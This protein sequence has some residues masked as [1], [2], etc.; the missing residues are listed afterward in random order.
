M[1]RVLYHIACAVLAGILFSIAF[2]PD[3]ACAQFYSGSYQ[4]FGKNRI[5]YKNFLWTYYRFNDFDV[6]FYLNGQELAEKTARYANEVIP[7]MEKKLETTLDSKL[8]FLVYNNLSDL[9]QSN[10]GLISDD[11]YNTGGITHIIGNKVFIYFDGDLRNF[12]RQIRSGIAEVLLNQLFLGQSIGSQI[13]NTTLYSLPDWYKTG[14]I[15]YVSE[16]WSTELDNRT[17]DGI[18]SGKFKKFNHLYGEDAIIAGHSF[19][20]FIAEQYGKNSIAGIINMT[21]VSHNLE[22]G[23]LYVIGVS[24]KNLVEEWLNFYQEIYQ[25][26]TIRELPPLSV[27]KRYKKDQV[28]MEPALSPDGRKLAFA[29]NDDGK[30]IIYVRDLLTGK[31]QRIFSGGYRLEDKIDYSYPLMKWNP[32]GEVL[33]FII[34]RK[35]EIY[36]YLYSLQDRRYQKVLLTNFEKVADYDYSH[37]GR[38]LVFSAVQKGQSDIYVYNISS[39]SHRQ[40]TN[41]LYDDLTPVF[42]NNSNSII[43]AS[44]RITDTLEWEPEDVPP[45]MPFSTDLFI[46]DYAGNSQVLKRLT[47]TP[48][49]QEI[50]PE[51]SGNGSF[52]F[53][54][55]ENGIFN[56]HNGILDSAI[57]YIDTAVHYRYFAN[58]YP[59]TDYSRSI[60][61]QDISASSGKIAQVIFEGDRY[62][63]FLEDVT[64]TDKTVRPAPVNTKYRQLYL[65][66][67]AKLEEQQDAGQEKEQAPLDYKKTF[68][69][70]Y[71][72]SKKQ[73]DQDTTGSDMVDIEDYQ[74]EKQGSLSLSEKDKQPTVKIGGYDEEEDRF[75]IPKKLN[76]RVEYSI[77][78]MTTQLDFTALNYF[79]QP[80][81]NG[82]SADFYNLGLNG[83]F[84]VSATD[85]LEDHRLVGGFRIP[86]NLR[87]IEYL[88]S[89]SNMKRRLNRE[90]VFYRQATENDF[91]GGYYYFIERFRSYQFYYILTY[92]FTPVLSVKGTGNVRYQKFSKLST[93]DIAL[94]APDVDEY[95]GGL[96]GELIYD[97]TKSLGLNLYQGTRG[98]FFT[99]Y[100]QIFGEK[101]KNMIVMGLDIRNYLKIHRVFIW[102]NRFAASRSFGQNKLLYYMGGVD[103]WLTP[104]FQLD[105]PVDSRQNYAYQTLAT[106]MRGFNQNSR[107]GNNFILLNSELRFPVFRYFYNRP[108]QSEFV[109]NFQIVAFGDL[110]TAWAGNDPYSKENSLYTSVI[111]DGSLYITVTEQKEPLIGGFGFGARSTLFG[112][113][114]RGDL[115][116][117]VEDRRIK[118]P[119][120]YF[121]L[122]LDF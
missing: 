101:N 52:A 42:F 21:Q 34:E 3:K 87:N 79:Y 12:E 94:Q 103:N 86:L 17:R 55:D 115:A 113:F 65:Q 27:L 70:V 72:S 18:L 121:S 71:K 45:E 22:N 37:D 9:K 30:Y 32:G 110:G 41:D 114:L 95:W 35:G 81:G 116:W 4:T 60:L 57:S 5:Q 1:I 73:P 47:K 59:G 67:M 102:A 24:Y 23:F 6:Y 122:S 54:S 19:W 44:N 46:Y 77:N 93:N 105:T 97:D 104:A 69:N 106:N 7:R 53:L 88:F 111:Q 75:I 68:R 48:Y 99:E 96:K 119:I 76:Y 11:Q 78:E 92:P 74:F 107:N 50:Q 15:S 80:Y 28:Y 51:E 98:K 29:R 82:F 120:F 90:I 31:S 8:Q 118:S 38:N 89:Y 25:N 63:I 33:S 40:I 108:I 16:E 10:I 36:L 84:Q 83:F 66:A 20:R 58:T 85:L 26:E 61:T 56:R 49:T 39:G 112:Y 91:L 13:K 64:Q 100:T 14:L 2:I 43:F 117:G 109:N 62:K